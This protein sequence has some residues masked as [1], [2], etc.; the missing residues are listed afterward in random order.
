MI[1][2]G[3]IYYVVEMDI[4]FSIVKMSLI[5]ECWM[6][7]IGKTSFLSRDFSMSLD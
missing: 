5:E 3:N 6:D 7:K 2:E 4:S 1:L